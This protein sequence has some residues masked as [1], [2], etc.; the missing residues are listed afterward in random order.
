MLFLL[1][2]GC[3]RLIHFYSTCESDT[4]CAQAF[5]EGST[6]LSDGY[7][8][9]GDSDVDTAD[10]HSEDIDTGE[11]IEE[12]SC[13]TH[14]ECRGINGWG[15]I[16][17]DDGTC[18]E[19]EISELPAR[20]VTY[21]SDAF[22]N[23]SEYSSAH[24]VGAIADGSL[25]MLAKLAIEMA[26]EEINDGVVNEQF[27]TFLCD[28]R[29]DA[30]LPVYNDGLDSIAATQLVSTFLIT[31]LHAPVVVGPGISETVHV[32]VN[33]TSNSDSVFLSTA[34]GDGLTRL[35]NDGRIW[36]SVGDDRHRLKTLIEY[37]NFVESYS[38]SLIVFDRPE[39]LSCAAGPN[40]AVVHGCQL[41]DEDELYAPD[42][43]Q[44]M[45]YGLDDPMYQSVI[46]LHFV[47]SP[48]ASQI[49][50]DYLQ[51]GFCIFV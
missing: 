42:D 7:C 2:F 36:S 20:C 23:P 12:Q 26:T 1:G 35:T 38:H 18:S 41:P 44:T 40:G 29:N 24:I 48:A 11:S 34:G 39:L 28:N 10:T 43:L 31:D 5:G 3:T 17:N 16:C 21:P 51:S 19:S 30:D 4:E 47:D 13:T 15:S 49:W 9:L 32:A 6:C 22:E 33:S 25:E 14:R 27:V 37:L 46:F 8:S 45:L 50:F